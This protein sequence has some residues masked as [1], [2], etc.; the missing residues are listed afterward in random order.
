MLAR[1]CTIVALALATTACQAR[2]R[3]P[4]FTPAA[5]IESAPATHRES[6]AQSVSVIQ[7]SARSQQHE[8]RLRIALTQSLIRVES[9]MTTLCS[10]HCGQVTLLADPNLSSIAECKVD[11][12]GVSSLISYDADDWSWLQFDSTSLFYVLAHE[13]GHHLDLMATWS[14]PLDPW[15][16]EIRAD[17]LAGCALQLDGADI[18]KALTL[19]QDPDDGSDGSDAQNPPTRLSREA[20]TQGAE[21]CRTR[22]KPTL[23]ALLLVAQRVV[24]QA[25]ACRASPKPSVRCP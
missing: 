7:I 9:V 3:A 12:P 17:V 1:T 2:P 4:E 19:E 20:I 6:P 16:R 18:R 5:A 8:S 13:Y 23:P 11:Q 10:P 15:V 25:L 24:D 14:A 22:D 21:A